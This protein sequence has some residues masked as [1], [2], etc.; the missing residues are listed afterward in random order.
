MS[1]SAPTILRASAPTIPAEVEELQREL[2][3]CMAE[4]EQT[5]AALGN[6]EARQ[7]EASSYFE[8]SFYSS[9]SLKGISRLS[10]RRII[11]ANASFLR[12]SGYSREEVI[13]HTTDELNLWAHPRERDEF[14][15]QMQ[16]TGM[17]RGFEGGLRSKSG[18]VGHYLIHADIL[19]F[20]GEPALLT[21]ATDVTDR[22]RREQVQSATYAIS[23]A[24]LAG[25][26][27]PVLFAEL[28]RIVGRRRDYRE[29][30]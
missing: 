23:Q 19:T 24:V 17:V 25:G 14:F 6:H 9:P 5:R 10:D 26:E 30:L 28:H 29:R 21:V 22:Q 16:K 7:G 27:L 11:E 8:K 13:G 18:E 20:R 15:A 12:A 2:D 4:L 3:K 1:Q